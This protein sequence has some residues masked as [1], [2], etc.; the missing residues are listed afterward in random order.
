M[1]IRHGDLAFIGIDKLPEGL[2]LLSDSKVLMQGSGGHDHKYDNGEFYPKKEND[3]IIGYFVAK[4]T[5]LYHPD[6][7]EKVDGS[8]L[9]TAKIPDGFYELRRQ[10]EETN[11]GMKPVLD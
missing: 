10:N 8:E 2:K 4:E 6:H 9:R 5:T 11:D 7:G 3:F 1:N